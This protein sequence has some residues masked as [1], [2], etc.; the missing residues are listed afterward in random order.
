M[1]RVSRVTQRAAFV[2]PGTLHYRVL[3]RT[4]HVHVHQWFMYC[5]VER[6][7]QLVEAQ[8][9]C[10]VPNSHAAATGDG[11]SVSQSSKQECHASHPGP[12]AISDLPAP[13]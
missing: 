2:L 12:G 4:L 1:Q 3:L 7:A 10:D 5:L 13:T 9:G 11:G 8:T 6:R